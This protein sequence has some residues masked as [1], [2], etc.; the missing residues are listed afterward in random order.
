MGWGG[1]PNRD[2]VPN[3]LFFYF[4]TLLSSCAY[5]ILEW[6]F[7]KFEHRIIWIVSA[8]SN[9]QLQDVATLLSILGSLFSC[10]EIRLK[11]KVFG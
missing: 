7:V 9:T 11:L 3:L 2:I 8:V 5:V 10:Q 4:D 1:N 6:F